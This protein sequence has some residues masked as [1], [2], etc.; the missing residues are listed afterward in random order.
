MTAYQK[1]AD[2]IVS[3]L[4]SCDNEWE[5]P[6]RKVSI[7]TAPRNA[8]SGKAY[9][10]INHAVLSAVA[11]QEGYEHN[12]WLT[13]KQA[14]QLGGHVSKGEHGIPVIFFKMLEVRDP[15]ARPGEMSSG[16]KTIP[17][18]RS[19]TVFNVAQC[20]GL[21]VVAPSSEATTSTDILAWAQQFT[22]INFGGD[23]AF[24]HRASRTIQMPHRSQFQSDDGFHATLLHELI[25]WTG[26]EVDRDKPDYAFEEL[27]AELGSVFLCEHFQIGY[28]IE[29]HASYLKS[30]LGAL[31]DDPKYIY[32]AAKLAEQAADYLVGAHSIAEAA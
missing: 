16:D 32:K 27:V 20:G 15:N 7:L 25:H 21:T 30:W 14:K 24:H 11:F 18:A 3:I 19:Y 8:I 28:K 29:H 26:A 5:L 10:G 22:A 1:V 17:M 9:R 4:Q 12:V 31:K 6:W 13:Y 2:R 23:R